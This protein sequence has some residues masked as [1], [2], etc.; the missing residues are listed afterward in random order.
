MLIELICYHV[1]KGYVFQHILLVEIFFN[2]P[3]SQR[4]RLKIKQ[5]KKG[6]RKSIK[7]YVYFS[8]VFLRKK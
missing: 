7:S 3:F 1:I 6:N 5:N 4:K 2:S 8:Y